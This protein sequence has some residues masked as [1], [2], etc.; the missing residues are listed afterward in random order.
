MTL[1][2][3]YYFDGS[4]KKISWTIENDQTKIDQTR[5]HAEYYCDK[6]TVEQSKYIALHVGVFWSI[7]KFIIKNGDTILV[8]VD[9]DSMYEHLSKKTKSQD[10]FIETRTNFIMQ[11]VNQRGLNVSYQLIKPHE[12]H[13]RLL[14]SP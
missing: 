2:H 5:D 9:L 10:P 6:V 3:R 7:G 12:N 4:E 13:A 14:L 8:M 11:L 1:D